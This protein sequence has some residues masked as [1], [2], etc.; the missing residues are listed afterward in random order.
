MGNRNGLDYNVRAITEIK[1]SPN[2]ERIICI[3]ISLRT[4][5]RLVILTCVYTKVLKPH[6]CY[7][8]MCGRENVRSGY[9][10]KV[11]IFCFHS[12]KLTFDLNKCSFVELKKKFFFHNDVYRFILFSISDHCAIKNDR[13]RIRSVLKIKSHS[14]G[15]LSESHPFGFLV[16]KRENLLALNGHSSP[17]IFPIGSENFS[18]SLFFFLRSA[19]L[20]VESFVLQRTSSLI[21]SLFQLS[22]L[23]GC[24][25]V[26]KFPSPPRKRSKLFLFCTR[27]YNVM[28]FIYKKNIFANN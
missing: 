28:Y 10:A 1:V 9:F 7:S 5:R 2:Y 18:D 25:R 20:S 11:T 14:I 4:N 26:A 21:R 12:R 24:V 13:S 27:K 8:Q 16:S 23:G 19:P 3:P 22:N 6:V 17:K 15:I